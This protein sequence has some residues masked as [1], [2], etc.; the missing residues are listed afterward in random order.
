MEQAMLSSQGNE[1]LDRDVG[2]AEWRIDLD[3]PLEVQDWCERF[4]C[5]EAQLRQAVT[6]F[7]RSARVVGQSF[8]K[9]L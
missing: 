8:G 7:G 9:L 2:S 5:T 6:T 4:E 3:E 1:T